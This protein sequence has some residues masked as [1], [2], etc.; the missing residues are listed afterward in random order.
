MDRRDGPF[1]FNDE[2][3]E[4]V[5]EPVIQPFIM[6]ESFKSC[7]D[8]QGCLA[9]EQDIFDFLI[10]DPISTQRDVFEKPI[11]KQKDCITILHSMVQ[12]AKLRL[13]NVPRR[14]PG[15]LIPCTTCPEL[16]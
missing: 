15:L 6:N 11:R 13:S 16:R 2:E 14:C 7:L 12:G 10:T 8:I 3:G 4:I 5:L 1:E 9:I